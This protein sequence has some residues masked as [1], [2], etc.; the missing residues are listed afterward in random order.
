MKLSQQINH[1]CELARSLPA[2]DVC[3]G[4]MVAVLDRV[5]ELPSFLWS[6]ESHVLTPD[7][8]VRLRLQGA[9]PAG[10]LKVKAVCLPFVLVK[11]P[12]GRHATLDMRHCRLVRLSD[13]F[14]QRAWKQLRKSRKKK[15]C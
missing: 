12:G 15:Q 5:Y 4:D 1:D 8:P 3:C 14:A 2:E 13:T 10:P 7:E 11:T 9:R 6:C